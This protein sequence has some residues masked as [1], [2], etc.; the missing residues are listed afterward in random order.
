[1]KKAL[2][3][4]L[5]LWLILVFL[6]PV[7]T[8]FATSAE[9]LDY[10]I[11]EKMM[12]QIEAGSGFSGTLSIALSAVPE[13]ESE[14]IITRQPLTF[15]CTY[16]V[17][18]EGDPTGLP[19]EGRWEI[20]YP[21]GDQPSVTGSLSMQNGNVYFNTSLLSDDWYNLGQLQEV[22]PV[23]AQPEGEEGELAPSEYVLGQS[24]MP[25]LLSF[26][27]PVFLQGQGSASVALSPLVTALTTKIDLWIEGYRKGTELDKLTDGTST[28]HV[29]YTIPPAAIKAQLKQM[30]LDMLSDPDSLGILQAFLTREQAVLLLNP[31]KQPFYFFAIDELPLSGDM[32]IQRTVSLK[33]E[34]LALH[35]SLPLFDQQGGQVTLTY[36]RQAGEGDLP[37]ENIIAV[38]S[39]IAT[40]RMEYQE[41]RSMTDVTVYQGTFVRKSAGVE[42]GEGKTSIPQAF[43]IAFSL[44]H[45]KQKGQDAEQR[46]TLTHDIKVTLEPYLSHED[47]NGVVVPFTQG[48]AAEY[49]S[50]PPLEVTLNAVFASKQAKNAATTVDATLLIGGETLPGQMEVS[51][52]GRTRPKWTPATFSPAKAVQLSQLSEEE[53]KSLLTQGLAGMGL[54]YLPQF[55][56]PQGEAETVAPSQEVDMPGET[57]APEAPASTAK[58]EE[59]ATAPSGTDEPKATD[60][61]SVTPDASTL[62][63]MEP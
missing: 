42:N 24:V 51:F 30:M 36:D 29:E 25:S 39:E 12:K 27:A 26:I 35:L 44:S 56:F 6:L 15:D 50:F 28:M 8:G 13:R 53:K 61:L 31:E 10:S 63:S 48:E 43:S 5:V 40:L 33:G 1:M 41:Y 57:D 11:A 3:N 52:S 19:A 45:Q 38:E 55:I 59:E 17:V 2:Q 54:M 62:P 18:P 34:T 14:A 4:G 60:V 58:P 47:E 7:G 21:S 32:I 49:L 9:E 37:D 46:E 23:D 22:F 20:G 16:I